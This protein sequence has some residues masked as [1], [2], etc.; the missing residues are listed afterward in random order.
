MEVIQRDVSEIKSDQRRAADKL[1]AMNERL[2]TLRDKL[3]LVGSEANSCTPGL[4]NLGGR[5]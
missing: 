5:R 3:D 1:D 2:D 4:S